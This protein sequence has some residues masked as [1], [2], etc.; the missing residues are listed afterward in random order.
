MIQSIII[1]KKIFN[2]NQAIKWIKDNGFILNTNTY[3]FDTTNYYRFRQTRP[4]KKY[5]YR[6]K[7][8]KNGIFFVM[9]Y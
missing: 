9:A 2:K 8:I 3:N 4:L 1:D 5:K 6:M 7:F